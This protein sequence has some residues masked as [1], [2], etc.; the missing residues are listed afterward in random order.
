[1]I[2]EFNKN[3]RKQNSIHCTYLLRYLI[4]KKCVRSKNINMYREDKFLLI[5]KPLYL[6]NFSINCVFTVFLFR[7]SS[8]VVLKTGLIEIHLR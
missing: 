5:I 2:H 7:F 1:M 6:T 4:I 8:H 3:V